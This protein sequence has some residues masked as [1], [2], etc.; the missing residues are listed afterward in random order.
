MNSRLIEYLSGDSWRSRY[1]DPEAEGSASIALIGAGDISTYRRCLSQHRGELWDP[2][3]LKEHHQNYCVY[4][5]DSEAISLMEEQEI[6]CRQLDICSSS[7][8]K[9]YDLI[10]VIDVIEHVAAPL[11]AVKH[12]AASLNPGGRL[13]V[14]TPNC[15]YWAW[16]LRGE[17]QLFPGD[18][19]QAYTKT[20]LRNL[21]KA[22]GLKIKTSFY[23][24]SIPR[25]DSLSLRQRLVLPIHYLARLSGKSNAVL[26]E[27]QRENE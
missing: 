26:V 10:L 6:T 21:G 9:A 4:D 1:R 23:Y 18:H 13:V 25:L 27:F 17:R 15:H 20:L 22:A 24:Q 3:W 19:L 11:E 7:L 14:T 2:Y 8:S 12:L 5:L 16:I